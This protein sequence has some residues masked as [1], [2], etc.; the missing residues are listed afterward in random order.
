MFNTFEILHNVVLMNE[1][2]MEWN[3]IKTVIKKGVFFFK[4]IG[5]TS[6]EKK[7]IFGK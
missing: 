1:I 2:K 3:G 7:I 4:Q 6:R 5:N